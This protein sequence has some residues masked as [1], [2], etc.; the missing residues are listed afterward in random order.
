MILQY[1]C[2]GFPHSDICGSMDIC[3]YPQL[4]AACHVLLRLLMPRHSSYALLRLTSSELSLP[5]SFCSSQNF[6]LSVGSSSPKKTGFFRYFIRRFR[7]FSYLPHFSVLSNSSKNNL[8]SPWVLWDFMWVSFAVLFLLDTSC[9]FRST[10]LLPFFYLKKPFLSYSFF[11]FSFQ[12]SSKSTSLF[13]LLFAILHFSS[14]FSS[15]PKNSTSSLFREPYSLSS[16]ASRS[17]FYDAW[18]VH[19]V[20]D[21]LANTSYLHRPIGM[22]LNLRTQ[23]A[24][25]IHSLSFF[26]SLACQRFS[27]ERRWSSRTFRYGYLV[28]TSP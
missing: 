10:F 26:I 13:R 28:T 8:C 15:F 16:R 20:K 4:F 25:L 7:L 27:L 24:E 6:A 3:S 19:S 23:K 17:G 14:G 5:A 18:K 12:T 2:S 1:C 11:L 9:S 21:F 22:L